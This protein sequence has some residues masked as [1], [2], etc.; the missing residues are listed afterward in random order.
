MRVFKNDTGKIR[1]GW[2]IAL[3]L[4]LSLIFQTIFSAFLGMIGGAVLGFKTALEG[5]ELVRDQVV[6]FI[7]E[8]PVMSF[9][10]KVSSMIAVILA[11]FII[12]NA[13]DKRNL[14]ILD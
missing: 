8:N 6:L 9:I 1:S 2:R 3:V 13:I 5:R 7:T 14:G 12:V 4:L 11:V 10:I